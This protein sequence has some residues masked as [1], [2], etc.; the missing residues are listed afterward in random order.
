MD[1][2]HSNYITKINNI[3]FII[4]IIIIIIELF[5]GR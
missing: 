1:D 5:L 3:K 2:S 4:I